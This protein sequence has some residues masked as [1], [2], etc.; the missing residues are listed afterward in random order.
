MLTLVEVTNP[1]GS[2]LQLPLLDSS[3]GY[4]VEDIEGLDPVT[5]T[6][7]TSSL[8]QVDG[9]TPQNAQRTTRN[10]TMTLGLQPD[11]VT[12]SVQSLRSALYDYLITKAN[13]KMGFYLDGSLFAITSGQVEDFQNTIFSAD[14]AVDISIICYDPDFYAP[15][16]TSQ[17]GDTVSDTTTMDVVYPGTTETGVIF[18]LNVNA[19]ITGGLTVYNTAPDNSLQKMFI[20]GDYISGD[21]VTVNTIPLQ[22][23]VTL[24]RSGL[25]SSLLAELD[26]TATWISLKKGTNKFR[27][28]VAGGG[29][30]PYIVAFTPKY[31]AI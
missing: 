2:T 8:A 23:A 4:V 7:T 11:F 19:T 18:T 3:A 15:S 6:L 14:P 21:V 13:V 26:P 1:L 24:T 22:K 25:Q 31:G 27:S 29:S 17:S 9:A 20:D 12:N 5:A 16:Q 10:I 28:V 30:I